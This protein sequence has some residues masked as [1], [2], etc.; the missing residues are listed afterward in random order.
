MVGWW[1]NLDF[2]LQGLVQGLV[3]GLVPGLVQALVQGLVSGPLWSS[4][5]GQHRPI[6]YS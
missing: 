4:H 3:P 6:G 1:D 5:S 2:V